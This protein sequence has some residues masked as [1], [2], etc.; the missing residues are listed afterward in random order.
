MME[1][2]FTVEESGL[3]LSTM[4]GMPR[5]RRTQREITEG[6]CA[7]NNQHLCDYHIPIANELN[8]RAGDERGFDCVQVQC[9]PL[10]SPGA[11]PGNQAVAAAASGIRPTSRTTMPARFDARL[12][13][14]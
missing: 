14:A 4:V 6:I 9:K 12:P 10:P 5:Y 2:T 3:L 7:G 1:A 13:I 11:P 8:F